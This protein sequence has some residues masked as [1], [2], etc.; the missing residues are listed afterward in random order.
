MRFF[1]RSNQP[2]SQGELS[3]ERGRL[4]YLRSNGALTCI[5]IDALALAELRVL[6]G[7]VYWYLED[8]HQ[9]FV[10]I[11]ETTN[12]LGNVRRYLSAWRGFNYH[13]LLNFDLTQQ[14]E[15]RLWPLVDRNPKQA[16]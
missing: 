16:A 12:G 9:A 7:E 8:E 4:T 5:E 13:G 6:R 10:L 14:T 3:I 1:S 15:L 2:E 11:P